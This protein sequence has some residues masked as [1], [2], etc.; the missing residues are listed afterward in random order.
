MTRSVPK[1][2]CC[3]LKT[4]VKTSRRDQDT[5]TRQGGDMLCLLA[6]MDLARMD[7]CSE[8]MLGLDTPRCNKSKIT[9]RKGIQYIQYIFLLHHSIWER[10]TLS[11]FLFKNI[12][13]EI[14]FTFSFHFQVQYFWSTQSTSREDD[15]GGFLF[16]SFSRTAC[17]GSAVP[18]IQCL[19]GSIIIIS[20]SG[21][22]L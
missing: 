13:Q 18:S 7:A 8:A 16:S 3:C 20:A 9:Q 5:K 22:A 1:C 2:C 19:D 21:R 6:W 17:Y 15:T 12:F 10:E 11:N 14:L 4:Q